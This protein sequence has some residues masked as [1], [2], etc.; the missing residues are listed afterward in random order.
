MPRCL[1][2]HAPLST[3]PCPAAYH[4]M[5]RCLPPHAPL[6]TAS[7]PAGYHPIHPCGAWRGVLVAV[8][9]VKT[10][11]RLARTLGRVRGAGT[12]MEPSLGHGRCGSLQWLPARV[13]SNLP[14]WHTQ[15]YGRC[16]NSRY[17]FGQRRGVPHSRTTCSAS[18]SP[19]SIPRHRPLR[20]PATKRSS[21]LNRYSP[22]MHLR[23]DAHLSSYSTTH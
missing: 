15:R 12:G 7:C 19:S 23:L 11:R 10:R 14:R 16:Q 22:D 5:P 9:A 21:D 6:P 2:P 20:S 18:R 1:P 8:A 13:M 3:T 4:P 17:L